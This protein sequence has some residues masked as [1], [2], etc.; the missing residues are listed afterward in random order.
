MDQHR[1]HISF[2]QAK[3]LLLSTIVERASMAQNQKIV[4]FNLLPCFCANTGTFYS[5][6]QTEGI[7]TRF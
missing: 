1:Y 2:S 5:I 3:Q 4:G 7:S 6:T